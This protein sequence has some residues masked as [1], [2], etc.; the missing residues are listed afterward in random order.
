[1]RQLARRIQRLEST[2]TFVEV[3]QSFTRLVHEAALEGEARLQAAV[4]ILKCCGLYNGIPAPQGAT[5]PE[6]ADIA[7]H[8]RN[9]DRMLAALAS[10]PLLVS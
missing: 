5:E 4:H 6:D 10:D 8:R 3:H 7:M 1:M 2:F 9:Y